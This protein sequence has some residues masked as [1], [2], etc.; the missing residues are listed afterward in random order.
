[1]QKERGYL[2]QIAEGVLVIGFSVQIVLGL[3]WIVL[4][5]SLD[6]LSLGKMLAVFL[7]AYIT[8]RELGCAER[9]KCLWGTLVLFT[10]PMLAQEYFTGSTYA[11]LCAGGLGLLTVWHRGCG[12]QTHQAWRIW[13]SG[14]LLAVLICVLGILQ[15]GME[16]DEGER[17]RP[18][19]MAVSRFAWTDLE[20]VS[21]RWPETLRDAVPQSKIRETMFFADNVNRVLVPALEEVYGTD[22]AG[23]KQVNHI[24]WMI[25]RAGLSENTKRVAVEIL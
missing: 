15:Y 17:I 5:L 22:A 1:M 20:E 3:V 18:A 12:K 13:G 7:A 10:F 9:G 19:A 25:A 11:L 16:H 2:R 4:H 14:V 23:E 8:L 21:H 24:L 6:P